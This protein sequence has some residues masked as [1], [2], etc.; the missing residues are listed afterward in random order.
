MGIKMSKF[1]TDLILK[2]ITDNIIELVTPLIYQSDLLK[3]EIVVPAGFQSDEA[4]VPRLPIIYALYGNK[5]HR[6]GVLHDF[7]Y[8]IDCLFTCSRKTKDL[9][10]LEAMESRNKPYYIR[11]SMYAGVRLGG[12]LSYQKKMMADKLI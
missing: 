4:S 9:V 1:I 11:Y 12:Y 7:L 8:R 3:C 6:E 5:A 2:D 10:F